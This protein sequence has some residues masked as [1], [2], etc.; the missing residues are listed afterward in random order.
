ME[1]RLESE[2]VFLMENI[3]PSN[4]MANQHTLH[5]QA[6]SP[7]PSD[8]ASNDDG[9]EEYRNT[10]NELLRNS[11]PAIYN[12]TELADEY[13]TEERAGQIVRIIEE[14]L[15]TVVEKPVKL[16]VLYLIDSLCKNSRQNYRALF[17]NNIVR[18]FGHVYE[19]LGTADKVNK[20]LMLK[21]RCTWDGIFDVSTLSLLDSTMLKLDPTWSVPNQ[22][23]SHSGGVTSSNALS[24]H[25][26]HVLP[27]AQSS[28]ISDPAAFAKRK[29]LE[30]NAMAPGVPKK[31]R[32]EPVG[33]DPRKVPSQ[34]N[35]PP[36][37]AAGRK[38][39]LPPQIPQ[40]PP[41][42][43]LIPL[44][45][46][47]LSS[48][49][50]R[51][52]PEPMLVKRN[53]AI[54][55]SIKSSRQ[56][57][58]PAPSEV[59]PTEMPPMSMASTT[60]PDSKI[61]T[62]APLPPSVGSQPPSQ[63]YRPNI[64][65]PLPAN[66][67]VNHHFAQQVPQTYTQ[68][69]PQH[70]QIGHVLGP[71]HFA[72]PPP[73]QQPH[74][75][76][77]PPPPPQHS[78]FVSHGLPPRPQG[79]ESLIILI[80]E[81]ER[82]LFFLDNKIAIV[83]DA[84]LNQSFDQL[85]LIDPSLLR[86]RQIEFDGDFVTVF[87]DEDTP[88]KQVHRIGFRD[89]NPTLIYFQGIIQPQE[90]QIGLPSRELIINSKAFTIKFGGSPI[91]IWLDDDQRHLV[92][93]SDA[94]PSIRTSEVIRYDLWQALINKHLPYQAPPPSHPLP[95][96]SMPPQQQPPPPPQQLPSPS[97]PMMPPSHPQVMTIPAH[98]QPHPTGYQNPSHPGQIIQQNTSVL[99]LPATTNKSI[100]IDTL[101]SKIHTSGLLPSSGLPPK[102]EIGKIGKKKPAAGGKMKKAQEKRTAGQTANPNSPSAPQVISRQFITIDSL[103]LKKEHD[104]VVEQCYL[105]GQCTNCS[106]RFSQK[107][108]QSEGEGKKSK[109]ARHLDWH[110]RMNSREKANPP[111]GAA[112]RQFFLTEAQWMQFKE[113]FD[114]EE[115]EM[116]AERSNGVLTSLPKIEFPSFSSSISNYEKFIEAINFKPNEEDPK[117]DEDIRTICTMSS[118]VGIEQRCTICNEKMESKW[119]VDLEEWR[120][121]DCVKYRS[122]GEDKD[123][124]YHTNCLKELLLED[125]GNLFDFIRLINLFS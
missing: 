68:P 91:E 2:S 123:E 60:I 66:P 48:V 99:S 4:V 37:P 10:L 92:R 77:P 97:M 79:P 112:R 103:E 47:H 45:A 61:F 98:V 64:H 111:I 93:L 16:T 52:Q 41:P 113:I 20:G 1:E 22:I 31:M 53:E 107:D 7:P 40:H 32:A 38:K 101:L 12:L 87:I 117:N 72:P 118:E 8:E 109:Y 100:D 57:R 43:D 120:L 35:V 49:V 119:D 90:F 104:F 11:K 3:A 56:P 6:P 80:N 18:I 86:P 25:N 69:P 84:D 95:N 63:F 39:Q 76:A 78:Q 105:G 96:S 50:N 59:M 81:E 17:Q 82:R 62:Q 75:Q 124:I 115:E 102:V 19:R 34:I 65:A 44:G 74:P 89:P 26:V 33:C 42:S 122:P 108:R 51:K 83:V 30:Q 88:N 85:A 29:A 5:R 121:L 46:A 54:I 36:G 94:R 14:R 114:D 71:H 67:P 70:P 28:Q 24:Q 15:L 125:H 58:A 23:Q 55:Q 13:Y 116:N 21:L 27:G 9:L 110:F 106:L 73:N